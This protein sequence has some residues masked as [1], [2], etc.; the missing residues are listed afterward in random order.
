VQ[1]SGG[2]DEHRVRDILGAGR[3]MFCGVHVTRPSVVRRL[4]DGEACMIRQ[5]YLP[6]IREGGEVRAFVA[7]GYFA[8]HSTPARYLAGNLAVL[9]GAP[10]RFPPAELRG[11]DPRASIGA[12]VHI[13]PPVRIGA[14]AVIGPHASIGPDAVIGRGAEVAAG[15][16]VERAVV[17]P[18]ALAEGRAVDCVVTPAGVVPAGAAG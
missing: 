8:E 16:V 18:G 4:P 7:R 2:D 12:S 1:P 15:A 5:G 6:W 11:V 10:I 14:G 3:H 13:V 9:R 17:W